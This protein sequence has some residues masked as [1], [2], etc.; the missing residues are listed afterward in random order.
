MLKMPLLLCSYKNF[1][2]EELRERTMAKKRE[3]KRKWRRGDNSK[4][5]TREKHKNS[6][7]SPFSS[8]LFS[9]LLMKTRYVSLFLSLVCFSLLVFQIYSY[10]D[11]ISI[12]QC[13]ICPSFLQCSIRRMFLS[14]MWTACF[15]KSPHECERSFSLA[16][17][18]VASCR[19]YIF[20]E[21]IPDMVWSKH[22]F[23]EYSALSCSWYKSSGS[24][25]TFFPFNA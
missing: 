15:N 5:L 1:E 17:R 7:K 3:D 2:R 14:Y 24:T 25:H 4:R 9:S 11:S 10:I 20:I 23:P 12:Q 13:L 22:T 8:L 19:E 21:A 16:I 18:L 6:A